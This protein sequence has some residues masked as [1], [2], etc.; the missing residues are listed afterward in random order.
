MSLAHSYGSSSPSG[1][2]VQCVLAR[3][4]CINVKFLNSSL[5]SYNSSTNFSSD[6]AM[7]LK[8]SMKL[9]SPHEK[10]HELLVGVGGGIDLPVP[11][12]SV[13]LEGSFVDPVGVVALQSMDITGRKRFEK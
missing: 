2:A 5:G 12:L 13:K 1:I 9:R 6:D 8:C 7:N 4:C 11:D 3:F 10:G